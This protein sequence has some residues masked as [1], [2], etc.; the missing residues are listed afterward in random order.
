M[1]NIQ[2][3]LLALLAH[4]TSRATPVVSETTTTLKISPNDIYKDLSVGYALP[5]VFKPWPAEAKCLDAIDNSTRHVSSAELKDVI[6][7]AYNERVVIN[8]KITKVKELKSYTGE[9]IAS[10]GNFVFF[11]N[12]YS[13][14]DK[15]L[16]FA[17]DV[18]GD[19]PLVS[20]DCL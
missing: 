4:V 6:K 15:T 1:L 9:A 14:V 5:P 2:L 13:W 20:R 19:I 8:D 18:Y 11:L 16:N 3:V 12:F 17:V 7:R 10:N